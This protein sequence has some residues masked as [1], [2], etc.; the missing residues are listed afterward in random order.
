MSQGR[1]TVTNHGSDGIRVDLELPAD[2]LAEVDSVSKQVIAGLTL[3]NTWGAAL[4]NGNRHVNTVFATQAA[5]DAAI[6]QVQA[7]LA[8][9][10]AR[11]AKVVVRIVLI[12]LQ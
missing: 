8:A 1:L 5:A 7:D 3:S 10:V 2:F 9:V 6:A 11:K 12:S 4:P